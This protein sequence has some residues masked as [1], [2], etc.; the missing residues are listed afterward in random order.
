MQS[1]FVPGLT[2]K[3]KGGCED[4]VHAVAVHGEGDSK[5]N[6][7]A[8]PDEELVHNR[9]VRSVQADLKEWDNTDTVSALI[10]QQIGVAHSLSSASYSCPQDLH[11]QVSRNTKPQMIGCRETIQGKHVCLVLLFLSGELNK[12]YLDPHTQAVI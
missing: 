7:K 12:P 10:I 1:R 4:H 3:G 5:V 6:R 11:I 9:P 2:N 8:A